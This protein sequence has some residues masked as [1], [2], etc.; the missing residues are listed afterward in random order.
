MDT[1]AIDLKQLF[2]QAPK[3]VQDYFLAGEID[4]AVAILGKIHKLP[5]GSYLGLKNVITLVLLGVVEPEKTSETIET[6][7]G[8][9][10]DV[11]DALTQDIDRAIFEKVRISVLGKK[12]P[13]VKQLLVTNSEEPHKIDLRK[14][15]L[16]TTHL[17]SNNTDAATKGSG[18]PDTATDKVAQ[19]VFGSSRIGST[20]TIT[21][22]PGS[23]SQL[24]EQLHMLETIPNDEEVEARL[25]TIKEQIASIESKKAATQEQVSISAEKDQ[26][27][28]DSKAYIVS[29]KEHPATYSKA[30]TSYN[31]DPYREIPTEE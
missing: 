2:S 30:P 1:S 10:R 18:V 6:H 28:E 15:L 27:V 20:R 9:T 5:I 22:Q 26:S 19:G 21:L 13:G 3:E 24:L 31:V 23:R 11:A 25:T 14:E 12:T 17:G 7:C 29:A 8:I 16:D 4:S